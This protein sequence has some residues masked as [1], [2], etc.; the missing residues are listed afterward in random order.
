MI[1]YY[2]GISS[3]GTPQDSWRH[4]SM[5]PAKSLEEYQKQK[6]HYNMHD[7]LI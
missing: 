2:I 6:Y 7:L 1:I 3:V 5:N 4:Q